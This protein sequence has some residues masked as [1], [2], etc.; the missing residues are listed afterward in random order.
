MFKKIF[1]VNLVL[2]VFFNLPLFAFA[3]V[4]Q[5]GIEVEFADAKTPE[6]LYKGSFAL[7]IGVSDYLFWDKLPGVKT[8]VPAVKAALEKHG[9][10]VKTVE[11]KP[12]RGDILAAIQQFIDD[13]GIDYDNWLLIY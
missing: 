12:T 3:Q 9:F 7:V 13:Y 10:T 4:K 11:P 1:A 2:A 8:D 5:K 6:T